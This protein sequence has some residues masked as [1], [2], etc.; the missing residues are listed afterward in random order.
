MKER[1]D[2]IRAVA[3]YRRD[4]NVSQD[5]LASRTGFHQASISRFESGLQNVSLDW[6][7][8]VC[9]ALGLRVLVTDDSDLV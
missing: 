3:A 2:L 6:F 1:I 9:K 5:V 8:T 4:C 7:L